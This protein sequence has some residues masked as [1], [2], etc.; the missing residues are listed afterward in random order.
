MD[1]KAL[2]IVQLPWYCRYHIIHFYRYIDDLYN[3]I[4]SH[5][6]SQSSDLYKWKSWDHKT[7]PYGGKCVWQGGY[8]KLLL[9]DRRGT[10]FLSSAAVHVSQAL[11]WATS[12][13][14]NT[15]ANILMCFY[16]LV[17][18]HSYTTIYHICRSQPNGLPIK[19]F[20][21]YSLVWL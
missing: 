20:L 16:L 3:T 10:W 7:F 11:N 13:S 12:M 17:L 18:N 1:V 9:L 15:E 14:R 8:V 19:F 21:K 5:L 4:S 6:M 2:I